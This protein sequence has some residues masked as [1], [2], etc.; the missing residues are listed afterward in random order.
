MKKLNMPT[1]VSIKTVQLKG[2]VFIC[3]SSM[4]KFLIKKMAVLLAVLTL[5]GQSFQKF[6]S[7][8]ERLMLKKEIEPDHAFRCKNTLAQIIL[9]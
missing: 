4:P 8:S 1:E 6:K 5:T 7:K 9:W 3:T 2:P